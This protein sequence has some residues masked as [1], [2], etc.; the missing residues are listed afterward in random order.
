MVKLFRNEKGQIK[1][2]EGDVQ[3]VNEDGSEIRH[4]KSKF[5]LCHQQ[6]LSLGIL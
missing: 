4:H 1:V 6:I 2:L 5:S 3:L